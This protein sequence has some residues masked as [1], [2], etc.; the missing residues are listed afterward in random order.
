MKKSLLTVA[1]NIACSKLDLHPEYNYYLHYSFIVQDNKIVEWGTNNKIVP[2]VHFGYQ[3]R[4]NDDDFKP[5]M[6]S[7]WI[8]YR[9]AKGLLNRRRPFDMINIRLNRKKEIKMSRPC[10]LP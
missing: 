8:A 3:A 5:K 10:E 2:A 9:R 7:E 4:L 1:Y 6:H